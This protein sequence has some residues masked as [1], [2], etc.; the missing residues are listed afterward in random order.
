MSAFRRLQIALAALVA[1]AGIATWTLSATTMAGASAWFSPRL[2]PAEQPQ[3]IV[4]SDAT[5]KASSVLC[6]PAAKRVTPIVVAEKPVQA[7]AY[8]PAKSTAKA[9]ASKGKATAASVKSKAT[10]AKSGG[11]ELARAQAL[12]DAQ[13]KKHP[14]LKGTTLSFGD[15]RGHQAVA[16]YTSGRIVI[17]PNHTASLEEIIAHEVWH[18]IDWRD[19]GRIDWGENVPR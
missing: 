11:N 19:N 1:V 14:I 8:T 2:E 3:T 7:S 15:A 10:K 18:I 12:L 13:I 9:T 5:P 6:T 17:S 16:Y 4:A